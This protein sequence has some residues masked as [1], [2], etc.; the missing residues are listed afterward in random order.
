MEFERYFNLFGKIWFRLDHRPEHEAEV[1]DKNKQT[2]SG[3]QEHLKQD[4]A[5]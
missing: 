3:G 5:T 1:A 2:K 4:Q